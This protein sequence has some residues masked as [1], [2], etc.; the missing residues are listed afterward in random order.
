ML[1][2]V[3]GKGP[4]SFVL[5]HLSL[6]RSA[7]ADFPRRIS[8]DWTPLEFYAAISAMDSVEECMGLIADKDVFLTGWRLFCGADPSGDLGAQTVAGFEPLVIR[9]EAISYARTAERETFRL[10]DYPEIYS[11]YPV[12]AELIALLQGGI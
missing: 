1:S 12:P 5:L 8:C 9:G 3:M 2:G 7:V 6:S 11:R 10:S 4:H